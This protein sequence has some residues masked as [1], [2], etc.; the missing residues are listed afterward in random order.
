M[1]QRLTSTGKETKGFIIVME[2]KGKHKHEILRDGFGAGEHLVFKTEAGAKDWIHRMT[3]KGN[4][5]SIAKVEDGR[6][7][8][9]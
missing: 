1:S 7:K 8:H 2:P 4:K 3:R 5:Y 6:E 9:I